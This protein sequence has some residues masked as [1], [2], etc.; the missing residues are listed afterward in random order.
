[1]RMRD[2]TKAAYA[3]EVRFYQELAQQTELPTPVCYYSDIDLETGWHVLLLE[4]LAPARTG[5]G[6]QAAP[7]NK[8]NW[9]CAGSRLSTPPGGKI[10]A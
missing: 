1:M 7:M 9:P 8:R 6:L 5:P 2:G 4:D 10:H 3:H